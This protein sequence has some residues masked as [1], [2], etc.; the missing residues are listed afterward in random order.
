MMQRFDRFVDDTHGPAPD[1]AHLS[2]EGT[3]SFS[4]QD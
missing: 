1:N 3:Y 4:P 2:W